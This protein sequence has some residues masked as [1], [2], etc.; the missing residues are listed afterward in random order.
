MIGKQAGAAQHSAVVCGV[1]AHSGYWTHVFDTHSV[2][3]AHSG[4]VPTVDVRSKRSLT[5]A[6]PIILRGILQAET[7]RTMRSIG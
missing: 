7:H 4:N 6:A 3:A 1:S 5:V 2:M